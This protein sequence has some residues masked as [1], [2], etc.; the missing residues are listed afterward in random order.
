MKFRYPFILLLSLVVPVIAQAGEK[1][2]EII[3]QVINA[4]GGDALKNMASFRI[5]DQF[6]GPTFGQGWSPDLDEISRNR[7]ILN[8]DIKKGKTSYEKW[9]DGRGGTFQNATI[10]DGEKAYVINYV[11]MTYGD[12]ASADIYSFAGSSMRTADA[13]L[14]WE[15]NKVRDKVKYLGEENYM[16]RPHMKLL[17]PF[18]QSPA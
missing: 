4:Y 5:D 16:N 7:Q 17:M 1:E 3:N 18:P 14:A 6:V 10:V 11:A 13:I 8:F 9:S 2:E 12:A 15:L